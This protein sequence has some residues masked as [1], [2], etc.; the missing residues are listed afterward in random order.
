MLQEQILRRHIR[1]V[2]KALKQ[3]GREDAKKKMA[4]AYFV[5]SLMEH[6]QRR[7]TPCR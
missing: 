1:E 7:R 2:K 4:T 5:A 6:E 3:G